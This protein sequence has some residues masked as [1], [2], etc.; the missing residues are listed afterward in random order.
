MKYI[1]KNIPSYHVQFNNHDYSFWGESASLL[2][3]VE[4]AKMGALQA[5]DHEEARSEI[6]VFNTFCGFQ[7]DPLYF[8]ILTQKENEKPVFFRTCAYVVSEPET[9]RQAFEDDNVKFVYVVDG[10]GR[11]TQY[12]KSDM[13]FHV[14]CKINKIERDLLFEA[15]RDMIR[16]IH[17]S[18]HQ[19]LMGMY[20]V[21]D[22]QENEIIGERDRQIKQVN[23]LIAKITYTEE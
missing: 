3:D 8:C 4:Y 14:E 2:Q 18:T 7:Y 10:S 1:T 9:V 13:T 6:S 22:E 20:E 21:D 23:D 5:F 17:D 12:Q 19:C 16:R 11:W 15:L